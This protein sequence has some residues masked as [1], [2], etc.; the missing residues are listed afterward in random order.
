MTNPVRKA[1]LPKLKFYAIGCGEFGVFNND[2]N[3]TFAI[4]SLKSVR[5]RTSAVTVDH[6]EVYTENFLVSQ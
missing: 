3:I 6:Q 1:R 4:N 2:N 5:S